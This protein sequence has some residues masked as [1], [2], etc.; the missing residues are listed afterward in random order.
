MVWWS[1]MRVDRALTDRLPRWLRQGRWLAMRAL[2][3]PVR[4]VQRHLARPAGAGLDGPQVQRVANAL[5]SLHL[6][7]AA[8][9]VLMSVP[10]AARSGAHRL[11]LVEVVLG[12]GDDVG[13]RA[14]FDQIDPGALGPGDALRHAL[15]GVDLTNLADGAEAALAALDR[16]TAVAPDHSRLTLHRLRLL[17]LSDMTGARF[18]PLSGVLLAAGGTAA[19]RRLH[20]DFCLA[21]NLPALAQ[22]VLSDWLRQEPGSAFAVEK[23]I[24]IAWQMQDEAA[25]EGLVDHALAQRIHDP[26]VLAFTAERAGA[27]PAFR[28][29]QAQAARQIVGRYR[30]VPVC[31]LTWSVHVWHA[32]SEGILNAPNAGL[33]R[34]DRVLARYPFLPMVRL[35]RARLAAQTGQ[36]ATADLDFVLRDAPHLPEAYSLRFAALNAG[37]GTDD[38]IARLLERRRAHIP[39]FRQAGWV[40]RAPG[41][42]GPSTLPAITATYDIE[43]FQLDLR[44]GRLAD[45]LAHRAARPPNRALSALLPGRY[46]GMSR[47]FGQPGARVDRL[48]VIGWEGVADEIRWAQTYDLLPQ[49]ARST[50]ISCEPRLLTLMQRSFPWAEIAAVPRRWTHHWGPAPILRPGVPEPALSAAVDEALLTRLGGCDRVLFADEIS[51]HLTREQPGRLEVHRAG[52]THGYLRPDP[53]RVALH[54][55]WLARTAGGLPCVGLLWRSQVQYGSR[56]AHY[57]DLD[58]LLPLVAQRHAQ[59]VVLQAR[60]TG[61]ELAACNAAGIVVPQGVDLYDDFEEIAALTAA[62][63]LVAGVSSL[64]YELAA[65]VGTPVWLTAVSPQGIYQR[66]GTCPDTRDQLTLNGHL[67]V[68]ETPVADRRATSSDIIG[69]IARRLQQGLPSRD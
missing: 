62:L 69:Q 32:T 56:N 34:L 47:A 65:A 11:Q 9:D 17:A 39:R 48:G 33:A 66:R 50:L 29:L 61:A 25:L 20:V 18:L 63:D 23:S 59:F 52:L 57:L 35:L 44:R 24:A 60:M 46:S 31:G 2:D 49:L 36:P 53:E 14:L 55:D 6:S 40:M 26:A 41:D 15:L 4:Q 45:A 27:L 43:S 28:R 5:M 42:P 1:R 13:A 58:D 10:D 19:L 3:P 38:A 54:R 22:P 21:R 12:L 68:P 64:P 37:P 51:F 8:R 7:V 16:I 67:I 30:A